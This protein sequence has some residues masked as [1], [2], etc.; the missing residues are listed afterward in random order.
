MQRWIELSRM[1]AYWTI[2]PGIQDIIKSLFKTELFRAKITSEEFETLQKNQI[3]QNQHKGER[4]FI[5]AC[6]PSIK[7]QNLKRLE[8]ENCI[9]V[10][11]FFVHPD[12]KFIKPSYYCIA[13]YHPPI[14]E[15]DWQSWM[16]E[17]DNGIGDAKIFFDLSDRER[18]SRNGLFAG[19][20][21]YCLKFGELL[22]QISKHG[23]DLTRPLP[24]PQSV[25]IMALFIA[26]FM[27]FRQ[28]YLLGCDHD[29]I[30]HLHA[31]SHFYDEEQ[32]ALNRGSYNEW[33]GVDLELELRSYI[34]LWEQYKAI[35]E[36]AIRDSVEIYNATDGGLLDV[37][38]RIEYHHIF[39]T[40]INP[41][42]EK[43]NKKI[44]KKNSSTSYL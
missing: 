37:F 12:F 44:Y 17:V 4:C 18:N 24:G 34:R 3:F 23:I 38:P 32:H 35:R 33:M 27:G 14:T 13:P 42:Y 10:S 6:G 40:V 5:L 39:K 25:S 30:L 28:I 21:I 36:I 19:R 26:M 31:S 16:E 8:G 22:E 11:N 29:W 20:N 1:L 43:Q 15:T 7:K 2:P 41:T 9:A